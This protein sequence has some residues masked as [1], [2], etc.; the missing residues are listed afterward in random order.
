M[1]EIPA[2]T[3]TEP[4]P[5]PRGFRPDRKVLPGRFPLL[6]VFRGLEGS[7]PFRKYP[8]DDASI[9]KI[10][11]QT[12]ANVADGPGWMY[13]APRKT[14]PEV[15]AAGFR[16]VE[17][18][19]DEIVVA[20]AHLTNSPSMDLYLDIIHEFLHILQRKQGRELWLSRNISYV[21]RP[22]EVEAYAFSVCEARRLH[23]PDSYLREYLRVTWVQKS[24]YLRLLR[25]VGVAAK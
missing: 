8:G 1:P 15:R 9:L 21:D 12:W 20:R 18:E 25:H 16:M 23:V 5:A 22:T 2:R 3:G 10:A 13:V 17:S 19:E 7:V 14:P 4:F 24:E 11:R 6:D